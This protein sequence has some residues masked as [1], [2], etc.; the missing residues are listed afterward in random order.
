MNRKYFLG[1]I[2]G[3]FSGITWAIY[4]IINNLLTQNKIFLPYSDKMYIPILTIIFMHDFFSM[5]WLFFYLKKNKKISRIK[6]V[7]RN[8]N[9]HLIFIGALLGGPIGMSGYLLGI[10]YIG[11]SYM[12]SFSSFYLIIGTF[13]STLFLKEKIKLRMLFAAILNV[14]GIFIIN[15]NWNKIFEIN[16]N[17][18]TLF[19]LIFLLFCIFGWAS[20]GLIAS[21]I[22][23]YKKTS[24]EPEVAIF[25]RQLTSTLLYGLLIIPYI[26]AYGLVFEIFKN[27]ILLIVAFISIVGSLSFFLWYYSMSIIG[28][29]KGISLNISYILWTIIFEVICFNIKFQ[30]NFILASCLFL[31]SVIL[32]ATLPEEK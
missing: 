4:T 3:I 25:I 11:A 18:E 6:E 15:F 21:Y 23:K 20:E 2:A 5:L 28:V 22:L 19:G 26:K 12:A 13:L 14:I 29:A 16:F 8:K 1:I 7:L 32:I 27:E 17:T 31:I 10:K 9:I 24:I 30:I